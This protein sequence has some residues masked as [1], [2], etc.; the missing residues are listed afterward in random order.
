MKRIIFKVPEFPHLSE[1]F[2]I[3]QIITAIKLGY[4]IKILTRKLLDDTNIS[5][6]VLIE[7]YC[8]LDKIIIEDYAIPKNKIARLFK[9]ILLLIL[10]FKDI[11]YIVKFYKEYSKFSLTWL[12]QW[13][14]YKQFNK[15]AIIHIQYGTNKYPIDIIKKTGF[16]K[17]SV[18]VTFHG[19]DAFF[20]I[21]GLIINNGYYDNLFKFGNLI[22]A[23][24][25]YLSEKILE[26]GCPKELLSTIPVGVD[27][28]FFYPN[29]EKNEIHKILKLITVGRLDKVK[30]HK[31]SIEAVNQLI[32]KGIG[33]TL[34][35]I[36]EGAERT[37]LESLIVK[38]HLENV[39]FIKGSK[40]QSEV[41]KELWEHDVYLLT[42]ISLPDGRCETQ[43]LA[44]LE[45][46]ACG[47]PVI[48][49]DSGG[50]KYTLKNEVSGFVCEE[51]DTDTIV[52]KIIE[53]IKNPILLNK[54]SS[55]AV[56]FV[57]EN[58]SQKAID[59]K[60]KIIYSNLSNEK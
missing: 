33:V 39:I 20:P 31:F 8:L 41:R 42:A 43:G 16:F 45:A 2:I 24:T 22:T 57:H 17:P 14:F 49:F 51:Y 37:N 38:Y 36:G 9:W 52:A 3:A 58:Y 25:P 18:I 4:E 30:G 10:S 29:K 56:T 60:W 34:T 47:L 15:D 11:N 53:L 7:K 23:N 40:L 27:T 6:P 1:T 32:N 19:H 21:N 59:D 50:V 26:L 48:V 35:I 5:N 55:E 12:Y 54:M 46:Q 44:T 28:Q 13:Y